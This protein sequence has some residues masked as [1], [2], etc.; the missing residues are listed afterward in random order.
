MTE[1]KDVE[2][3]GEDVP[4]GLR[5]ALEAA[6]GDLPSAHEVSALEASVLGALARVGGGG[7]GGGGG[8][9]GGGAAAAK[10]SGA[11]WV[12]AGS[13]AVLAI[14]GVL[15]WR[16]MESDEVRVPEAS[17]TA[18]EVAD[19]GVPVSD[20]GEA[21]AA[22]AAA[23]LA[24][25][26]PPTRPR[27]PRIEPRTPAVE[28]AIEAVAPPSSVPEET[29]EA[30]AEEALDERALLRAA[31][32][33]LRS[34]PGEALA[35]T[36]R[37]ADVPSP[38]WAEERERVAIES[39]DRLGRDAEARARFE[40]FVAAYPSSAYRARLEDVLATP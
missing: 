10:A 24:P 13:V 14:A 31:Q 30:P 15:A 4:R 25:E 33:A 28:E 18:R 19:A 32:R 37:M 23:E 12:Q 27:A 1:R 7:G 9:G 2:G 35:L 39:L 40:R 38:E 16:A 26:L 34:D 6:K 17:G 29:S 11:A 21:D 20:A 22:V 8:A 36:T 3:W 5:E